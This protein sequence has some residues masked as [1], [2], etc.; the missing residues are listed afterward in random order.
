M[1]ETVERSE[2]L[3][4]AYDCD[5]YAWAYDQAARLRAGRWSELD[6]ENI[7]EELESL[8]R[9]ERRE[10]MSRLEVLLTHLLK[11]Q[12]QPERQGKSW[13]LTI[14]EQRRKLER[15]LDENLSLRA[16]LAET[17]ADAYLDAVIEAARQTHLDEQDFPSVCPYT[18]EQIFEPE[19]LPDEHTR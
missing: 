6:V 18:L 8:G 12:Y 16:Q 13:R 9:G 4:A 1:A 3:A 7:A 17:I 19:F 10:L 5:L 2:T 14:K 11:W 15:H